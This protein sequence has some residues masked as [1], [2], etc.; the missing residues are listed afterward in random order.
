MCIVGG[1]LVIIGVFTFL[2]CSLG[3]PET[4]IHQIYQRLGI[5]VSNIEIVG[6]L[7]ICGVSGVIS[8][9]KIIRENLTNFN[10][11]EK[12]SNEARGN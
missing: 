7:L 6:G 3:N 9:L 12:Q 1:L 11:S 8:E 5:I 10:C 4:S 2:G